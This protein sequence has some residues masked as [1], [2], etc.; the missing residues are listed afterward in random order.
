ML[1]IGR[2]LVLNPRLLLLDEPLE[3][4]APLI[5]EELLRVLTTLVREEGLSAIFVEQHPARILAITDDAIVLERGNDRACRR[6]SRAACGP[7]DARE[8]SGCGL[9][10]SPQPSPASGRGS[11][12]L[13]RAAANCSGLQPPPSDFAKSTID[14]F[15]SRAAAMRSVSAASSVRCASMHLEERRAAGVVA[16]HRDLVRLGD[17]VAAVGFGGQHVARRAIGD[18]RIVHLAKRDLHRLRVLNLRSRRAAP[19][20]ARPATRSPSARAAAARG[21]GRASRSWRAR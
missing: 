21:R 9:T 11:D 10:P 13:Y 17:L 15:A 5:V 18:Q 1:A 12:D 20:R 16:Q 3:G 2:A 6:K 14:S 4:L 7:G 19:W 8:L